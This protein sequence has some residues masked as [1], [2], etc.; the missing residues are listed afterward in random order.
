MMDAYYAL[1]A[2]DPAT[3][4]LLANQVLALTPAQLAE[5]MLMDPV[6]QVRVPTYAAIELMLVYALRGDGVSIQALLPTLAPYDTGDNPY[7]AAATLFADT[8]AQTGDA[9]ASCQAM[10]AVITALPPEQTQFFEWVG[11]NTELIPVG[12]ICPLP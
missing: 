1:K 7:L 8:Y 11:Y 6:A 5:S 2:N 10:S 4:E 12:E 3:A 9:A